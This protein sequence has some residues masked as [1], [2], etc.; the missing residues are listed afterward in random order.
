[1]F[2]ILDVTILNLHNSSKFKNR[3]NIYLESKRW[4]TFW[5]LLINFLSMIKIFD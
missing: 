1:M 5:N 4:K 2:E 3:S